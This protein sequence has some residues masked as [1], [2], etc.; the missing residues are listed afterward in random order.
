MLPKSN[1]VHHLLEEDLMSKK[2]P[3]LRRQGYSYS[4]PPCLN[5]LD[6]K[7]C[8]GSTIQDRRRESFPSVKWPEPIQRKHKSNAKQKS[9]SNEKDTS[10]VEILFPL[11]PVCH[12]R[13]FDLNIF[14]AD[15]K[16]GV[17][18]DKQLLKDYSIC[19]PQ[20]K[21]I[22]MTR[23]EK[24]DPEKFELFETE[25]TNFFNRQ[26]A[27]HE[28]QQRLYE[29][30]KWLTK[31]IRTRKFLLHEKL[32]KT[33]E[34]LRKVQLK[35]LSEDKLKR[36]EMDKRKHEKKAENWLYDNEKRNRNWEH[37]LELALKGQRDGRNKEFRRCERGDLDILQS[38]P[39][40]MNLQQKEKRRERKD[41]ENTQRETQ[42]IVNY[43]GR[44]RKWYNDDDITRQKLEILKT[45]KDQVRR[46]RVVNWEVTESDQRDWK[47]EMLNDREKRRGERAR[48]DPET[49]DCKKQWN[50]LDKLKLNSNGKTRAPIGHEHVN[51]TPLEHRPSLERQHQSK[52]NAAVETINMLP[53]ESLTEVTPHTPPTIQK[54]KQLIQKVELSPERSP[55]ADVQLVPC[56]VC[57]RC[58][59]EN[60]LERHY[61]V[62]KKMQLSTRKVFISSKYRAKG[63]DLEKFMKAN[64]RSKTPEVRLLCMPGRC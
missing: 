8:P 13:A 51:G 17:Q 33:E 42:R 59:A 36:E 16:D 34:Q 62:C 2:L 63:T 6:R 52:I 64:G 5:M 55:D 27:L 58:F 40:D 44:E 24:N 4:S 38:C 21:Q 48:I 43:K 23:P 39:K 22:N 20:S 7:E 12:R 9:S 35:T 26:H 15:L 50:I 53:P 46:E 3:N 41:W 32:V 30:Q 60:R 18:K 31:D 11:K 56:S 14:K 29:N 49:G 10:E 54:S 45:K 28:E 19:T 25:T 47:M 37:T 1:S 57:H 61:M